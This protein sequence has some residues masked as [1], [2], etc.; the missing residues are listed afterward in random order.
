M[1]E[2]DL[3]QKISQAMDL[4]LSQIFNE[5]DLKVKNIS[6]TKAEL[7]SEIKPSKNET[8]I[9]IFSE[10]KTGTNKIKAVISFN[11]ANALMMVDLMKGSKFGSTTL[12]SGKEVNNLKMVSTNLFK[13]CVNSLNSV[14]GTAIQLEEP[15][16]VFSFSDFENEFIAGNLEGKGKLFELSLSVGGTNIKGEMKFFAPEE[17]IK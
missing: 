1:E 9:F 6:H 4:N 15:E 3:A 8:K 11:K 12:L 7:L 10:L 16:M 2:Q 14:L 13:A 17:M 5:I